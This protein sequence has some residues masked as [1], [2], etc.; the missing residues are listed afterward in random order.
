MTRE[1]DAPRELVFKAWSEPERLAKWWGPKG[2]TIE[3]KKL[4]FRAGGQFHYAM[5]N[6]DSVTFGKFVYRDIQTPERIV[7]VNSFADELGNIIPPPFPDPWPTEMLNT[8]TLTERNGKTVLNL[9][10]VPINANA[11][12][13]QT[14]LEGHPSMHEGYG[15][16]FDQLEEYLVNFEFYFTPGNK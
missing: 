16:T 5:R 8:V 6:K 2:F 1:F 15:G 10:V 4:D 14:F 3:V 9:R 11:Q 7:F 12:E 13:E